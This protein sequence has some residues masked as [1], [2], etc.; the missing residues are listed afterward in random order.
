MTT[1]DVVMAT[2]ADDARAVED[3][4]ETNARIVGG[5]SAAAD[6]L[7]RAS[8]GES[9]EFDAAFRNMRDFAGGLLE[10]LAAVDETVYAQAR[11]VA[12]TRPAADAARLTAAG[13]EREVRRLTSATRRP[14]AIGAA[15]G[16]LALART[17]AEIE[18]EVLLPALAGERGV[19]LA[20]AVASLPDPLRAAPAADAPGGHA[21]CACG[22]HDAAEP[23]ELDVREVPHAIRHATVFGAFDAVSAGGAM[24]LIAPHDPVP[25]LRQLDERSGGRL[26]VS[27]ERRGPEAWRLRLT[28]L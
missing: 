28:R 12:S 2:N 8:G 15:D 1:S 7:R 5:L 16:A 21:G 18:D 25:L 13:I 22:E 19:D 6:A 4:R 17:L 23:P 20:A 10:Y 27:Y 11:G 26:E 9:A 14:E 24:V 3:V